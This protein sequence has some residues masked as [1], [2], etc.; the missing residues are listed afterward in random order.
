VSFVK[1][2][3]APHGEEDQARGQAQPKLADARKW[4]S[5]STVCSLE[6][7]SPQ[8]TASSE[9]DEAVSLRG[10]EKPVRATEKQW[11]KST[12]CSS[13]ECTESAHSSSE[14]DSDDD[15]DEADE[16][17]EHSEDKT[18]GDACEP[19]GPSSKNDAIAEKLALM[20]QS[21][22]VNALASIMTHLVS[23]SCK[24][25]RPTIFHATRPP[26]ISVKDYLARLAQY[27]NC[28]DACLIMGLVY[29]DRL[30]K[31]HPQFVVSPLNVHRFLS[32]GIML[33]AKFHDDVYY[34]NTHYA[35][36]AGLS[37]KEMNKLEEYFL[38]MLAWRLLVRPDE[39]RMIVDHV[40]RS[41][42]QSRAK[43]R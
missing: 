26:P 1:M 15:Q 8:T 17:P 41:A 39:Y 34:S 19:R 31:M 36:V 35:R 20:G 3:S 24:P 40:L 23:L 37:L 5:G 14:E 12:T 27:Y 21:G 2:H 28:S 10:D 4:L 29:V 13:T 9:E 11:S 43:R 7:D 22:I 38:K 42:G 18:K 33:A 30:V 16:E 6:E 32:V 25:H